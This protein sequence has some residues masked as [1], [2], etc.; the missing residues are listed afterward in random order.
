MNEHLS[1]ALGTLSEVTFR[2]KTGTAG[3]TAV[4]V[5]LHLFTSQGSYQR[6][7]QNLYTLPA[8]FFSKSPVSFY[9]PHLPLFKK[10][11]LFRATCPGIMLDASPRGSTLSLAQGLSRLVNENFPP[12]L[13]ATFTRFLRF[14]AVA[15]GDAAVYMFLHGL[16]LPGNVKGT[17]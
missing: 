1:P 6:Q 13:G 3:G 4:Y 2:G 12:A 7:V 10:G 9:P 14:K 15:A 11:A 17:S 16:H 8:L 5:L